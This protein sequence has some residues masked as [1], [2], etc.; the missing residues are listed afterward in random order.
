[1]KNWAGTDNGLLLDT[2]RKD[3]PMKVSLN[4]LEWIEEGQLCKKRLDFRCLDGMKG[5]N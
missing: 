2:Y 5:K 3:L 1:M 4:G